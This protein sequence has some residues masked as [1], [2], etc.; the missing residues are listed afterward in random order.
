MDEIQVGQIINFIIENHKENKMT[1]VKQIKQ[2]F[3]CKEIK[4]ILAKVK[5]KLLDFNIELVGFADNKVISSNS[6]E[7]LFLI[8]DKKESNTKHLLNS[9]YNNYTMDDKLVILFTFINLEG[10]KILCKNLQYLLN[11]TK[12]FAD[13][14]EIDAF[15][16]ETKVFGYIKYEKIEEEMY[17]LYNWRFYIEFDKF[18]PGSV[19]KKMIKEKQI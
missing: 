8:T 1:S 6:A 16:T 4:D 10:D 12:L 7:R 15:L 11:E 17:V 13:Q 3:M 18:N 19:Y 2:K 9:I 14:K 5:Q